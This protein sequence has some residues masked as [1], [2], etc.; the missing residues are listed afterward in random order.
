MN[1]LERL[2]A[3]FRDPSGFL[4]KRDGVLYRQVNTSYRKAYDHLMSSGLY[5]A[6]TASHKMV[7]HTETN[8]PP[9]EPEHAYKVIQPELIPMISYPYEW[10]FSEMK[11]AALLTLKSDAWL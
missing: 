9:A 8:E 7:A 2:G 11:D 4:F 1:N 3:S 5:D 6:L 10:S